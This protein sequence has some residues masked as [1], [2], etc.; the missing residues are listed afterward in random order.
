MS[1]LYRSGGESWQDNVLFILDLKDSL[2]LWGVLLRAGLGED[3]R[4]GYLF[5]FVFA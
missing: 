5:V 3:E 4:S 1:G 2:L